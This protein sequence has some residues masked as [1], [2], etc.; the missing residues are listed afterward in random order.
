MTKK[1]KIVWN[2][3]VARLA[4][5][6][7]KQNDDSAY[8]TNYEDSKKIKSNWVSAAKRRSPEEFK[9]YIHELFDDDSKEVKY[10]SPDLWNVYP[11]KKKR[12]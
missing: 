10:Q 12:N 11:S 2:P 4:N 9:E 6:S 5:A 8:E 7:V 1:E 3:I